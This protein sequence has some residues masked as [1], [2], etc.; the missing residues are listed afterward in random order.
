MSDRDSLVDYIESL[1]DAATPGEPVLVPED[2]LRDLI[3]RFRSVSKHRN[4]LFDQAIGQ[5]E[6]ST[7]YAVEAL[8]DG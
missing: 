3:T 7:G 1:I 4:A 5:P 8:I 2:A 6:Q